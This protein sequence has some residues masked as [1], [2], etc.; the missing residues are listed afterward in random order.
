M[1]VRR[2]YNLLQDVTLYFYGDLQMYMDRGIFTWHVPLY[3]LN[4][5]FR[6]I[7]NI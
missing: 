5:H 4:E 2:G 1:T 6:K 7:I 3:T